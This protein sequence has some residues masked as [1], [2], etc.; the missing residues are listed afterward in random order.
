MPV[1][2][3]VSSKHTRLKKLQSSFTKSTQ[4]P[5]ASPYR[6]FTLQK[7]NIHM[8][9]PVLNRGVKRLMEQSMSSIHAH[10]LVFEHRGSISSRRDTQEPG[11][12]PGGM[13][14]YDKNLGQPG[15][16]SFC[17][18][19]VFPSPPHRKKRKRG[20]AQI[21]RHDRGRRYKYNLVGRAIFHSGM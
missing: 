2:Q 18:P 7:E 12:A 15:P 9:V 14:L 16:L 5:N 19:P 8:K 20:T 21:I 4:I 1:S 3:D 10:Q 11:K 6:Y 17:H 13:Y